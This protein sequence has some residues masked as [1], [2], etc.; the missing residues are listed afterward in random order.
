MALMPLVSVVIP[1]YNAAPVLGAALGSVQRQTHPHIEAIIVDDGSTDNTAEIARQFCEG[2]SRFRL[3]RQANAGVSVARNAAMEQARGEFIA[4]LDADDVWLP[5]KLARQISLFREDSRTK[6][7]FTNYLSW[8]GE[9]ALALCYRAGQL[10]PE[11]D[12]MPRLIRSC[13]YLTSTIMVPRQVFSSVGG[14]DPELREAQDWDIFLR[15]GEHGLQVRGIREPLAQYRRWPGNRTRQTLKF[16]EAAVRVLGKNLAATQRPEW[17][18]AYR[19]SLALAR[20]KLE[21]VRARHRI[22]TD[23]DTVPSAILRAWCFYPQRVEWLLWYLL[24]AWPG[25]LGGGTLAG[26]IHR[27]MIRKW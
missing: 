19:R 7:V 12:A 16:A 24:A 8:D 9:R 11:G 17:R 25:T 18:P 21:L 10:L 20:A 6:L 22:E 13:L 23:P 27:K 2:D 14:F 26:I 4:F 1:A 5:G 15:L 3:L